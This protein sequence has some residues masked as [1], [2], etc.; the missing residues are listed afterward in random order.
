MKG[1]FDNKTR[2]SEPIAK[3]AL[4]GYGLGCLGGFV[5]KGIATFFPCMGGRIS[6]SP[7][8]LEGQISL[9]RTPVL[10]QE[11]IQWAEWQKETAEL[12]AAL[13]GYISKKLLEVEKGQPDTIGRKARLLNQFKFKAFIQTMNISQIADRIYNGKNVRSLTN[14]HEEFHCFYFGKSGEQIAGRGKTQ[15][16][17]EYYIARPKSSQAAI[18]RIRVNKGIW[19]AW[20]MQVGYKP[21]LAALEW[22]RLHDTYGGSGDHVI[23]VDSVLDAILDEISKRPT[24]AEIPDLAAYIADKLITIGLFNLTVAGVSK[25]EWL[26]ETNYALIKENI[27]DKQVSA[28]L[29]IVTEEWGLTQIILPSGDLAPKMDL[30]VLPFWDGEVFGPEMPHPYLSMGTLAFDQEEF[31]PAKGSSKKKQYTWKLV[32]LVTLNACADGRENPNHIL[33]NRI[34]GPLASLSDDGRI[35]Q[36]SVDAIYPWILGVMEPE[37]SNVQLERRH[38]DLVYLHSIFDAPPVVSETFKEAMLIG[39][40]SF[41]GPNHYLF[42]VEDYLMAGP[43]QLT[44]EELVLQIGADLYTP[45]IDFGE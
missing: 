18:T 17:F 32:E 11:S 39:L 8:T 13:R 26:T 20:M 37:E 29:K 33:L 28:A 24:L 41:F 10:N 38:W 23:D 27:S 9:V 31:E 36:I 45:S 25:E 30:V 15:E 16:G 6:F 4:S 35:S 21:K 34:I 5:Q 14:Y 42:K 3:G 1:L 44:T 7:E 40:K 22:F 12:R 43:L 2:V 19:I